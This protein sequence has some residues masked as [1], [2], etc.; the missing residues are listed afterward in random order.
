MSP[1]MRL[2]PVALALLAAATAPVGAQDGAGGASAIVLQLAP[3]PRPLALGGA[4]AALARDP[5]ALFYNPGRLAGAPRAVAAAYHV[6]PVG[7]AAGSIA[8]TLPTGRLALGVGVHYLDLGEVEV[9]EPDPAYGGQRGQPTGE[10]TEGGEALAVVGAG[11]ELG[12]AVRVGAAAKALHLGLAGASDQGFAVDLGA[13]AG[14]L[15]GRLQLGVAVQNVGRAAGVGRGSPLPRTVRA[16]LAADLADLGGVRTTVAV[17]GVH[18]EERSALAAG[19]EAVY[20]NGAGIGLLARAGF[21]G[22]VASGDAAS[23]LTVGAGIAF[24]RFGLDY[25]YRGAGPLGATHHFGFS[26]HLDGG[27]GPV[28]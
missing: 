17:E 26:V 1:R 28:R 2:V 3:A 6:Y 4:Y 19:L 21:D 14:L 7:V 9:L 20:R 15:R 5:Y 13:A 24:G 18:V 27:A 23:P 22:R 16:A 11:L 10:T 25:A 8:A 12:P